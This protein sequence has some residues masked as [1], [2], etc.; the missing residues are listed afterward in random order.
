MTQA[1][2]Q[3]AVRQRRAPVVSTRWRVRRWVVLLVSVVAILLA[4]AIAAGATALDRLTTTRVQLVDHLDPQYTQAQNLTSVL[5]NQQTAISGYMLTGR[6]DFVAQYEQARRAQDEVVARLRGLGS[7]AGSVDRDLDGVLGSAAA[8]QRTVEP[9][10]AAEPAANVGA[11][12]QGRARFD[13]VRDGLDQLRLDLEVARQAA[14]DQLFRDG[15]VLTVLLAAV[16]VLLVLLFVVLYLGFHRGIV[17]PIVRLAGEVRTVTDRDIRHR[18]AGDGGPRELVELTAD[19]EAMR[20]R[21]VDEV[22]ELH[23][24]HQLLDKRTHELERSNA[25]LEQFAYIASHD[26]QE[27]LRK[28]ASFCQLLQRRY[29]GRLD[30]RGEQYIAYAVDGAKRMQVLINDLLVFSRVGR[31]AGEHQVVDTGELLDAATSNLESAIKYSGATIRRGELPKVLGEASL[32]TAVF[33]NLISNA[34]KFR[35]QD[36]PEV[37]VEAVRSGDEWLFS[38]TDKGIGIDAEYAERVFVI[39]QRLH[40][41]SAYPG[42]GIGLAMCRKIIEYHGGRI[43]LDTGAPDGTTRF[44]FTLPVIAEQAAGEE[45]EDA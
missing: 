19:I 37:R 21:I 13:T 42:T 33:Q 16:A 30:E 4:V 2:T 40:T 14:R 39:F 34:I 28:V 23:E 9:W 29:Q 1:A 12:E 35:G 31:N 15:S 6:R 7:G 41:R 18:V 25:D 10:T 38:F 8:W 17:R 24:A 27:P 43:W 22:S 32:L 36:P 11:V 20:Q 26:L 5:L 44:S 3:G 45:S